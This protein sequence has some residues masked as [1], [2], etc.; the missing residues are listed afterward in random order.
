MVILGFALLA[1]IGRVLT[2]IW[3]VIHVA[4]PILGIL[5]LGLG[6]VVMVGAA[7]LRSPGGTTGQAGRNDESADASPDH[8]PVGAAAA[9]GPTPRQRR[10]LR[11]GRA[12]PTR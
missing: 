5:L 11:S 12:R 6:V 10:S 3:Q 2:L 7:A 1:A 9:G 8:P 4:L